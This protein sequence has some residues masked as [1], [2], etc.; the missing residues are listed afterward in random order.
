MFLIFLMMYFKWKRSALFMSCSILR[1][2]AKVGKKA[3][4]S[5]LWA[6]GSSHRGSQAG[7][8][9][10]GSGD[11]RSTPKMRTGEWMHEKSRTS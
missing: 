9:G 11:G 7:R 2:V 1:Q 5:R 6:V 10:G 3:R 8:A 4:V